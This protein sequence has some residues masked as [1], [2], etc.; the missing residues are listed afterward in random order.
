M[1]IATYC[2]SFPEEYD[3]LP[4]MVRQAKKLGDVWVIDG[5]PRGHL[6]H[7]PKKNLDPRILEKMSESLGFRYIEIP[8]PGNPGKQRNS[9]LDVVEV[10]GYDWIIQNDS[11]EFW[12]DQ[13]I[14]Q[15]QELLPTVQDHVTNV[16][17]KWLSLIDDDQHY[18]KMYSR[19]ITH[20]RIHR[21]ETVKWGETWHEHQTFKGTRINTDIRLVHTQ[22]LF[23][24][25]LHRMRG[26]GLEGWAN[27]DHSPLPPNLRG[28]TWPKLDYPENEFTV[29]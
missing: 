15:I 28:L 11:D 29:S 26:H 24:D 22:F 25:R 13:S 2:I 27:L 23:L 21:P 3:I 9:A 18:C 6:C 4:N 14:E 20:G 5:G 7:H 10:H 19:H 8:W 1:K 16:R 17:V 12:P